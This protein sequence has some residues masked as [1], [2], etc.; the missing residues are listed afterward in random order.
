MARTLILETS[1]RIGSVAIASGE[2]PQLLQSHRFSAPQRH[3]I[4]LLPTC[5]DL[6]S[7]QG[8]QPDQI[9]M[10][11][12][13]SGPGS[14]TGLRIGITVAKTLANAANARLVAVPTLDAIARAAPREF[15]NL[16]V[17]LDAKRGQLYAARYLRNGGGWD[18]TM[19]ECTIAPQHLLSISPR[20]LQLTG[21]GIAYHREELTA[22]DVHFT[23]ETY[24]APN[25]E[26]VFHVGAGQASRG[27]FTRPEELAPT[28]LRPPEAEEVWS[29][30]R[31]QKRR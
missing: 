20:P 22:V 3:T 2:P 25:V 4:E 1:S 11:Y 16:A 14:F 17:V 19:P 5:H 9:K 23:D 12:V 18:K 28:Y 27:E 30:R 29:R 13:S 7:G 6:V 21:E 31:N 8:W 26:H 24:W 15:D 10:I